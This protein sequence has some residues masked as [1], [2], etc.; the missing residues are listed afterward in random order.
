MAE[1]TKAYSFR[2]RI[3]KVGINRCVDVPRQVSLVFGRDKYIPVQGEVEQ[4]PLRST[5]VPCGNGRHRLFLHSRIWRKLQMDA[6]DTVEV[7]L[8]LDL[9]SRE[10]PLPEDLAA[11]L[12]ECPGA[13]TVFQ[14]MTVALRREFITWVF[15]ARKEQTRS[16]RI[17]T[18]IARLLEMKRKK[19]S[20]P[21][22]E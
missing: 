13:L 10:I 8:A 19:R 4:L 22:E 16:K 21:A 5:V 7:T 17:Q 14:N 9:E 1:A 3:Y 11:A 2:A 20:V 6:G 12:A 15:S 18:G